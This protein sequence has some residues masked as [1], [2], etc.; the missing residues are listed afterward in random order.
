MAGPGAA[1]WA[2]VA[3]SL[4]LMFI[5]S[6]VH[7][8]NGGVACPDPVLCQ[9][10]LWP[11]ALGLPAQAHMLHRLIAALTGA[12]LFLVAWPAWR[13][14]DEAARRWAGG[15]AVLY[16]GQVAVGVAQVMLIMPMVLR[17]AHLAVATLFWVAVVGLVVRVAQS[18]AG[19]A[20]T[21]TA[22]PAGLASASSSS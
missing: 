14:P 3:L 11:A 17:G 8:T 19:L 21:A 9:G 5:G 18:R 13:G 10:Q 15:A 7:T 4:L 20:D 6:I 1:A 12:A 16:L 2:L 22:Q